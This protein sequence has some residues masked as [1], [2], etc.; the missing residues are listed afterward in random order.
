LFTKLLVAYDGSEGAKTALRAGIALARA[1]GRELYAVMVE[2]NLPRH[3]SSIEEFETVKEQKDAQCAR[4]GL[5]AETLAAASGVTLYSEAIPGD[6]VGAVADY[7]KKGGFDLLFIGFKGHSKLY[8]RFIGT[9]THGLM[10][11]SPC[12][13]FV[14]KPEEG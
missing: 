5:E 1:L 10:T 7:V 11:E 9:T 13:V 6:E 3:A 8:D 2:E 14:A 4:I 12:S